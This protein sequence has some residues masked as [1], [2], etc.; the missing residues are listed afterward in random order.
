MKVIT[1]GRS[2]ENNDIVVNDEKVS[3]N[4]LQ[5]VMDDNGNYSVVDLGSTNGTYVN[6]QRISGEVRLK[7]GDEVRI[8]QTALPWQNYFASSSQPLVVNPPLPPQPPKGPNRTWLY[9]IIGTALLLLI[10]GGVAWKIYHDKQKAMIEQE[11][12]KK[13]QEKEQQLEQEANDAKFEAARLS[14][15]AEAA[16]R[17]A[18]ET[19]SEK[20]LQYAKEMQEKAEKAD[21]LA[22]QKEVEWNKMK[23]ELDAARK[24]KEDALKQSE[25]DKEDKEK[26]IKEAEDAQNAAKEAED[27]KRKAEQEAELTKRFYRQ[28]AEVKPKLAMWDTDYFQKICNEMGWKPTGENKKDYIIE[29]FEKADDTEKQRIIN[30]VEKVLRIQKNEASVAEPSVERNAPVSTKDQESLTNDTIVKE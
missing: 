9:V 15:E 12:N 1:I 30:A 3:R 23:A 22:R 20:D 27:A 25:K 10:G 18:A 16:A 28:I 24:A 13:K 4:H 7:A 21:K 19:K 5:M 11:E 17:R 29:R 26:A 6:G 8:G 14:E 2:I